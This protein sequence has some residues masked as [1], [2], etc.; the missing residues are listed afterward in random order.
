MSAFL[1][2][3]LKHGEIFARTQIL[4]SKVKEHQE[5]RKHL[6]QEEFLQIISP[7]CRLFRSNLPLHFEVEERA[8]FPVLGAKS[9]IA[10][11]TFSSLISEHPKI[12]QRFH[13]YERMEY[14]DKSIETMSDLM[15]TLSV[16]A[17]KENEFFISTILTKDEEAKVDEKAQNIGFTISLILEKNNTRITPSHAP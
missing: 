14:H 3:V 9:R 8:L 1:T 11:R 13:E 6:S 2:L 7:C 5:T 12:M 10:R 17:R 16:H 15:N 4:E